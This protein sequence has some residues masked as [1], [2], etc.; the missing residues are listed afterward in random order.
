MELNLITSITLL[1]LRGQ[2]R[3]SCCK[4]LKL[5]YDIIT[6][7]ITVKINNN[8]GSWSKIYI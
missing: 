8:C 4:S 3:P 6:V 7:I 1:A 2:V 5:M